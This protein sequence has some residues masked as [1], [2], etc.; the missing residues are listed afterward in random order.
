MSV[1]MFSNIPA[2]M[3]ALNSWVVWKYEDIGAKKPTKIPYNPKNGNMANVND[4][5]TWASFEEA[6]N[7]YNLG[8]CSGIGFVFSDRDPYSFIDLDDCEGD[9]LILSLIHI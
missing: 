5:D 4:P 2:E 1:E 3:R 7:Y 6:F 8:N 9:P